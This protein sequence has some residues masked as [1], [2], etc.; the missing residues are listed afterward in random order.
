MFTAESPDVPPVLDDVPAPVPSVAHIVIS[1]APQ[2][3]N[4]VPALT[5]SRPAEPH[6]KRH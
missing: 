3:T 4:V 2:H 5:G 1:A 6:Y